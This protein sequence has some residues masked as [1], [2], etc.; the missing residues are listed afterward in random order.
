MNEV[1]EAAKRFKTCC[2]Y[3]FHCDCRE[4]AYG[5]GG[6]NCDHPHTKDAEIIVDFIINMVDDG[7]GDS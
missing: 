3:D 6:A 5:T 4:C 7:K 2:G 1:I